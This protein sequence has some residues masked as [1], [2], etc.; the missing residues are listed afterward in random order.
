[1]S[2][3]LLIF[4]AKFC[5]PLPS[6]AATISEV[7][8]QSCTNACDFS[9]DIGNIGQWPADRCQPQT[10][11]AICKVTI[12]VTHESDKASVRFQPYNDSPDPADKIPEGVKGILSTSSTY[13][14]WIPAVQPTF[15]VTY[16]CRN[17]ENTCDKKF[18]TENWSKIIRG[19]TPDTISR[20][21]SPLLYEAQATAGRCHS[22]AEQVEDCPGQCTYSDYHDASGPVYSCLATAGPTVPVQVSFN[23]NRAQIGPNGTDYDTLL[24]ACNREN[25]N[26]PATMETVK[27]LFGFQEPPKPSASARLTLSF[28]LFLCVFPVIFTQ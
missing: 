2:L 5:L 11:Y 12:S 13:T 6:A 28:Y 8:Q 19:F 27:K 25:C 20:T 3:L 4:I 26:N 1:M 7:S 18:I 16:R 17:N 14:Y 23:S 10:M 21:L 9:T 24:V 15:S 22:D